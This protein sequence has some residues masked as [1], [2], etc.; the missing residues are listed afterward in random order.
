MVR[1]GINLTHGPRGGAAE[2]GRVLERVAGAGLDH[3]LLGDHISFHDGHGIDGL[4]AATA[5]LMLQPTLDVYVAVYLLPLRHPVLVARQLATLAE[6]APGR[7]ILGIGVGGE[8]RHEVEICGVDPATR[9]RR[10]DEGMAALR[11]LLG[12]GPFSFHGAFFDFD[13]VVIRPAP[14]PVPLIVGGRSNAALRRAGRYGDGW[15]GI[16]N[17]ARR[18]VEAIGIVA[19]EAERAGRGE[20]NWQHG[21]QIWCGI[22]RDRETAR[23]R[24]AERMESVYKLRFERFE[25]YTPFGTAAEIAEYLRPYQG[26]GCSHFNLIPQAGDVEEAIE[27]AAEVKRLLGG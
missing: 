2:L 10:A 8:D 27:G 15:L 14:G 1:L 13:E 5:Y 18:F 22:G 4:V 19:A 20:V 16:W 21:M 23:Q 24:V 17:S 6:L 26:A 9:G 11:G 12:G 7:L 3:V 25:R